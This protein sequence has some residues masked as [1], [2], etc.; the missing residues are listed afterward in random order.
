[1]TLYI[2]K[3]HVLDSPDS[4]DAFNAEH[5]ESGEVYTEDYAI[6]YGDLLNDIRFELA[7]IQYKGTRNS[8]YEWALAQYQR[9]DVSRGFEN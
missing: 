3:L 4:A 6:A 9:D 7:V 2:K 8:A 1:M 5:C